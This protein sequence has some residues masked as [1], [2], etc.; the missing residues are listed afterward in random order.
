MVTHLS[1]NA[2]ALELIYQATL[3]RNR[4]GIWEKKNL[5]CRF[6]GLEIG[7]WGL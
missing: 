2:I 3:N 1:G 6:I 7:T 4:T 5:K